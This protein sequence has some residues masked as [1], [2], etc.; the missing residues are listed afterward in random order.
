MLGRLFTYQSSV[1]WRIVDL[2]YQIVTVIIFWLPDWVSTSNIH[3]PKE[4]FVTWTANKCAL[5]KFADCVIYKENISRPVETE[6][7]SHG[8][9]A[10]YL[11]C[12]C[13]FC[14][15]DFLSAEADYNFEFHSELNLN[16]RTIWGLLL[17]PFW[18]GK[19]GKWKTKAL[20]QLLCN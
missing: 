3:I 18:K 2:I 15:G 14:E 8:S 1:I 4:C 16:L 11:S 17:K 7:L 5:L 19:Y 12:H 6:S 9:K 10:W 20:F 13:Y